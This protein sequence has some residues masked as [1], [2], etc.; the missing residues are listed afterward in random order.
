MISVVFQET[1]RLVFWT[2][3]IYHFL[4]S[5]QLRI[6]NEIQFGEVQFYFLDPHEDGTF[7]SYAVVSVYGPPNADILAQS[8]HVL[9]A[10][11][12]TGDTNLHVVE[13]RDIISVV[14]MQPLPRK[15]TDSLAE[16]LWFVVEKS[17]LD[18]TELT[19]YVDRVDSGPDVQ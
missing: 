2:P 13:T 9:W 18:D 4:I 6:A 8:S 11:A 7:S 1:S 17:G 10:A 15:P 16:N 14:S 12:Y 3:F 19:G 5:T